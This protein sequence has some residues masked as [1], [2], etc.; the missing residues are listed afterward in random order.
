LTISKNILLLYYII[1]LGASMKLLFF[2]T[3]LCT[4]FPLLS[5]NKSSM[6]ITEQSVTSPENMRNKTWRESWDHSFFIRKT[7]PEDY[8]TKIIFFTK[9]THQ[10]HSKIFNIFEATSEVKL[11]VPQEIKRFILDFNNSLPSP[12]ESK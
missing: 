5:M 9:T 11:F 10:Q 1:L 3:T 7:N 12:Q 6:I 4:V 8:I 2:I